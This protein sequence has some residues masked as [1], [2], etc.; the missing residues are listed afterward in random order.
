MMKSWAQGRPVGLPLDSGASSLPRE[1]HFTI[2]PIKSQ[3]APETRS[4]A[5][6]EETNGY[7]RIPKC[8]KSPTPALILKAG[9]Q[10][11]FLGMAPGF[12]SCAHFS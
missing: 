12:P 11:G 1:T 4:K 2:T 9:V 7:F 8:K 3:K 10:R 5:S 6:S